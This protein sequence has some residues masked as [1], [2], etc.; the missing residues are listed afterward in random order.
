MFRPQMF[1]ALRAPAL[2]KPWG[3]AAP[4]CGDR[5]QHTNRVVLQRLSCA[6]PTAWL[7]ECAA[8]S[9]FLARAGSSQRARLARR[10]GE[11]S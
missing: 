10:R 6:P 8:P 9:R 5:S 4:G 3:G 2:N 11:A 7:A 1:L